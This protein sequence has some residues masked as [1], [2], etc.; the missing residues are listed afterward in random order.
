VEI[1]RFQGHHLVESKFAFI[2]QGQDLD[3]YREFEGA[4][5]REGFH[6]FDRNR[7][8]GFYVGR[9]DSCYGVGCAGY[10]FKLLFEARQAWISGRECESG[11]GEEKA[12]GPH[13]CSLFLAL[14]CYG[15]DYY[16]YDRLFV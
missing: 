13:V 1:G 14:D 5:H 8:A 15:F 12:D 9:A 2:D 10:E 7:P 11:G 3:R 6:A 16:R 4:R